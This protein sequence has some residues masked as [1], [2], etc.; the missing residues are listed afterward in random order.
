MI[1]LPKGSKDM[2]NMTFLDHVDTL[3]K[4]LIRSFIAVLVFTIVGFVFRT[5]LFDWIVF[6]PIKP[7][8][9]T[10][11]AICALGKQIGA[12]DMCVLPPKVNF[13]ITDFAG[14]FNLAMTFSITFGLCI[15][16]PYIVWELWSFIK[17]GLYEGEVKKVTGIVFYIS[18][19]FFI[20]V[21]FG[22]FI[23]SPSSLTFLATFKTS[24]QTSHLPAVNTYV[25]LLLT[26]VLACG[27]AFQLPVAVFL[28]SK[29]GLLTPSFMR[30]YRRHAYVL[31]TVAAAII[32]PTSDLFNLS[33]VGLPMI[34]LYE[35]SIFISATV[36][37]KRELEL[38]GR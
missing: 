33:I 12:Q 13:I 20:G 25:S 29:L 1:F 28:L 30:S 23:L 32:T 24:N 27:L 17:P 15:S 19:L 36:E 6:S 3:R 7:D 5:E 35:L 21:A 8:F 38:L 34:F 4:H 10:Y 2:E 11:K 31:I 14:E 26:M 18:A 9:I 22:Y 37:K 16:F